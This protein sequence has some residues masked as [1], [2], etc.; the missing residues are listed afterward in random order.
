MASF[1][2]FVK[3]ASAP[4]RTT[5]ASD[6]RGASVLGQTNRTAEGTRNTTTTTAPAQK[7][8]LSSRRFCRFMMVAEPPS[9]DRTP[10][11]NG[12]DARPGSL[13]LLSLLPSLPPI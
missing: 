7:D 11:G 12:H 6:F 3:R 13:V 10:W 9:L 5:M 1:N 8:R 2:P 4:P